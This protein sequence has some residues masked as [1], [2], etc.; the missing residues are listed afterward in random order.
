MRAIRIT[1]FGGPEVLELV[2]DQPEPEARTGSTLLEVSHAGINYADTHQAE[3]SYL[4]PAELPL[5]PGAEAVGTTPD[6]RRVVALLAG[7]GY[8]ERAVANDALCFEVPDGVDD[9]QALA[10]VL[11]GLTAWHLLRNSA[12]LARGESVV[13]HAAAGGVGTLAVQLAKL[14]GAGPVIAVASSAEKRA[15]ASDLGADVTVDAGEEDL[16]AALT[17]AND[18]RK[19]DVV[20]EMVGGRTTDQSLAALAPFGRLVFFGMASRRVPSKVD[21]GELM[22]R[23]RGVIGFWLVHAMADPARHLA[24]PMRELLDL[25]AAGDLRPVVGATYGLSE[26]PQAHRDLR[27]RRSMG[28]LLLDPSR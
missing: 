5:V 24:A 23:S 28:K 15:L 7:G 20:L 21:L 14:Y 9:G 1:Q 18:G 17:A 13:I 16:K 25:T 4:A 2:D 10:L 3:N 19:V 22:G 27:E 12:K 26:A 8:A 6:G 11:Q